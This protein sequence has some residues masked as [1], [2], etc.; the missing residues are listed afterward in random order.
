MKVV[1]RAE[2]RL[3]GD[4]FFFTGIPCKRGHVAERRTGS[5]DCRICATERSAKWGK[6]NSGR[7]KALKSAYYR[8]NAEG[9]KDRVRLHQLAN[10][11]KVKA[12]KRKNAESNTEKN[13]E[14]LKLYRTVNAEHVAAYMREYQIANFAVIKANKRLYQEEHPEVHRAASHNRRARLAAAE[15]HH[16]AQDIIQINEA[17]NF[18]CFYCGAST[19]VGY[20]VDHF[21]ALS[22]GGTNWPDN[23]RIACQPCNSKKHNSAPMAFML[24]L[25]TVKYNGGVT[26]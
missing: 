14:R 7:V 12:Y 23:L 15:G 17:Q 6:D 9:I 20:H 5:G 3:T 2:A 13:R 22:K 19:K 8:L 1:S 16:S 25:P 11:E 18:R 24:K 4:T 10:P 26:T 21:I